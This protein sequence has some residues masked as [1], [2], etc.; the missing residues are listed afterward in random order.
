MI[1]HALYGRLGKLGLGLL[2][3]ITHAPSTNLYG[4]RH[5]L[6]KA[7]RATSTGIFR[8][9]ELKSPEIASLSKNILRSQAN[10]KTNLSKWYTP[11]GAVER[12]VGEPVRH[13]Q[14]IRQHGFKKWIH[15]QALQTKYHAN[16]AT[17][18]IK[19]RSMAG[20]AMQPIMGGGAIGGVG[21]G[22]MSLASGETPGQATRSAIGWAGAP[23]AMMT[24]EVGKMGYGFLKPKK[25]NNF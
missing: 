18:T 6:R 16:T 25:I 5:A 20:M 17:G 7:S 4:A 23:T 24:Y 22:A 12:I 8:A 3:G 14:D 11:K 15:N 21:M 13:A 1:K 2:K 19:K 9:T 10:A